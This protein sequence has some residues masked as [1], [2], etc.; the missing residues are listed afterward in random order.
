MPGWITGLLVVG[1][2]CLLVALELRRPLRPAVEPKLKRVARNLAVSVS[3]A[4]AVQLAESPVIQPLCSMVE[5]RELGLLKWLPLP[6]ALETV[7]ALILMDYTLY[8]WHRLMHRSGLIWR[9]HLPH[10]VD[11]DLDASTAL[12]FHFSEL[13][14]SVPWR[15]AQVVII[16]VSPVAFSLWQTALMLSILFHH[17]NV[18]LPIE[19]EQR[20][21]RFIVT[22]RMHGIHHSIIRVEEESNLSSGLT[23]WDALHGTLKL[24]VPQEEITI[25]VPAYRDPREVRWVDVL[26]MPFSKQRPTWVLPRNG[27]PSRAH[28]PVSPGKLLA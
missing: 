25:E 21:C 4:V 17:S 11:L 7:L 16:G 1:E 15:A 2:F 9:F 8:I 14:L 10:H 6:R 24:N 18:R 22:P 3:S 20:L 27:E 28:I 23:L 19:L 26:I 12:R 13:V 5:R